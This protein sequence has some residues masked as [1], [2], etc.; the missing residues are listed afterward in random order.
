MARD[1]VMRKPKDTRGT[2]RRLL[3]YLGPWRY[4]IAAVMAYLFPEERKNR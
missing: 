2:L 4:V 1:T 3:K